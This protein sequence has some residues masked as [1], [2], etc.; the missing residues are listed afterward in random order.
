MS[1]QAESTQASIHEHVSALDHEFV[2]ISESIGSASANDA[3]ATML[4]VYRALVRLAEAAGALTA[5]C[6]AC[7]A[8]GGP[9]NY[10]QVNK[11]SGVW[12]R[13]ECPSC[14]E[15]TRLIKAV[16]KVSRKVSMPGQ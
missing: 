7:R 13:P 3:R 15:L 6:P 5:A 9:S 10:E 8:A 4:S 16:E 11:L 1:E 2:R 14:R 12:T